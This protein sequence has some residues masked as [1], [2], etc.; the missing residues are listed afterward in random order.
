MEL[1]PTC[2]VCTHACARGCR[3]EKSGEREEERKRGGENFPPLCSH[4]CAHVG[5]ME[6]KRREGKGSTQWEVEEEDRRMKAHDDEGK[7]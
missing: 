1:P 3:G 5:R 2:Y 7:V 6:E 4:A